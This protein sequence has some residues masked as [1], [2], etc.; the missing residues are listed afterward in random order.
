MC[1]QIL[2]LEKETT[3]GQPALGQVCHAS[4]SV[5]ISQTS[6]TTTTAHST[7]TTHSSSTTHS[8]PTTQTT[9]CNSSVP[10]GVTLRG[11]RGSE[12][13]PV[14]LAHIE[15]Q[16]D[17]PRRDST[18]RDSIRRDSTQRESTHRD[19]TQSLASDVSLPCAALELKH[20]LEQLQK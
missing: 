5:A 12:G 18:H 2:C 17:S 13:S 19:S 8:T 16:R 15:M 3:S 1:S 11:K 6:T 4:Q 7:P 10:T 14:S 20:R 9:P